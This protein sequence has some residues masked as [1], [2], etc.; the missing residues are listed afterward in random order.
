MD[1]IQWLSRSFGSGALLTDSLCVLAGLL[2][3]AL[4]VASLA[5]LSMGRPVETLTGRSSQEMHAAL[6]R[7]QLELQVLSQEFAFAA[8]RRR[9]EIQSALFGKRNRQLSSRK[10]A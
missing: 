7:V 6:D 1:F 8:I 10:A 2:S 4:L 9:K 5:R 3:C